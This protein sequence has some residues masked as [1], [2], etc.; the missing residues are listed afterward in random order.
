MVI[1]RVNVPSHSNLIVS[2]VI[3][4]TSLLCMIKPVYWRVYLSKKTTEYLNDERQRTEQR[5]T[6]FHVTF[7]LLKVKFPYNTC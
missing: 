4:Y 3:P 6:L 2:N 1:R 7:D 5:Q